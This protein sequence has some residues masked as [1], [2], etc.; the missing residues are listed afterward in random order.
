[1]D[2]VKYLQINNKTYQ[3]AI[4]PEQHGLVIGPGDI[5]QNKTNQI[6]IV[7]PK[8]NKKTT[9]ASINADNSVILGG[10]DNSI[11]ATG[12]VVLG[13]AENKIESTA[14]YGTV[15]GGHSNTIQGQ[16]NVTHGYLNTINGDCSVAFGSENNI[17]LTQHNKE[18]AFAVGVE[19]TLKGRGSFTVGSENTCNGV[20]NCAIGEKNTINKNYGATIGNNLIANSTQMVIGRWN[21][22]EEFLN[23]KDNP[24]D[25]HPMFIVGD[26]T[27]SNRKNAFQVKMG[28]YV[29]AR[30]TISS[31][32]GADYAEYFEWLDG[33]PSNEDR[34]G[35]VVSLENEKI[36]YANEND[37][38][39]GIISASPAILADLSE[40]NW[41]NKYLTD[42]FGRPIYE[43]I[44]DPEEGEIE[45]PVLNP[46]F[47]PDKK[48]IPRAA[49]PEW[50]AVGLLGK[51]YARDDG[52]CIPGCY[53]KPING[54]L[55]FSAEPT[56]IQVLQRKTDNVVYTF[57][58]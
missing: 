37:N 9:V 22:E 3:M 8:D 38:I 19:N 5:A 57:I 55:T 47:N 31:D 15:L 28:G 52:T 11:K 30:K 42:D 44:I 24:T 54:V 20:L 23:S 4:N 7:A 32:T 43:T 6:I 36:E 40:Q 48:Y 41:H 46:E 53:A 14:N 18:C 2:I 12:G 25:K 17:E 27:S 58:R 56:R 10:E 29:W 50:D 16:Y 33:N 1:M 13:G 35:Y 21:Q 34:V 26:G 51:L 45:T 49:R 39:L